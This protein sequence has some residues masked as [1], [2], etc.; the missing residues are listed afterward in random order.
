MGV[1]VALQKRVSSTYL[2]C[3]ILRISVKSPIYLFWIVCLSLLPWFILFKPEDAVQS[4]ASIAG[5]MGSTLLLWMLVLGFRPMARWF[6]EDI[7]AVTKLHASCGTY[8]IVAIL[9][10]P[11]LMMYSYAETASWL[12]LPNISSA[13]ETD[14]TMGRVA[15]FLF[16]IIWI[17]SAV[18]R[19]R[20]KYR[21]WLYVHYL[22]YP[23]MFLTLIHA[24]EI[25]S[26]LA[27]YPLLNAF[28][29]ALIPTYLVF[30]VLRLAWNWGFG[31][32]KY[33]VITIIQQSSDVYVLSLKSAG[34]YKVQPCIGQYIHVQL[35]RGGEAHPFSVVD[36][37]QDGDSLICLFRAIGPFTQQ[38]AQITSGQQLWI[39]G[40]YGN[41]THTAQNTK[42]KVLISGGVGIGPFIALVRE[43]PQNTVFIHC[44]RTL[45]D[46]YHRKQL[47]EI[48][49]INFH[50]FLTHESFE[51]TSQSHSCRLDSEHILKII[52][53][54][55]L[56]GY[57]YY[58]CGSPQF[59]VGIIALLD[60]LAIPKQHIHQEKFSA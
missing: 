59:N 56:L 33:Q 50:E 14:I 42:P 55:K 25:G 47:I 2:D 49:G 19:S 10:H 38:L 34:R 37:D 36:F 39:D 7:P 12:L 9:L 40:P 51:D 30:I 45:T 43:Y 23:L 4:L 17:T 60:Q 5:F 24:R 31:T 58:V 16:L 8:G 6:S 20:I 21:P 57:D 11:I 26:S 3:Y 15:L 41:F 46:I 27:T 22:S 53:K 52:G 48:L 32:S 13:L 44:N 54:D 1:N 18:V 35:R 29:M 28:W